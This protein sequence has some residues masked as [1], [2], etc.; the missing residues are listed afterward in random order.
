VNARNAFLSAKGFGTMD[1][2]LTMLP[3]FHARS[4]LNEGTSGT[5]G[6]GLS[7]AIDAAVVHPDRPVIHLSGDS[8]IGFSGIEME[9]LCRYNFP[10]KIAVLNDGG[11]GPG[12]PEIPEH[13]MLNMKP[14]TLIWGAPMT[15]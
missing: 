6:V 11:V 4:C 9:M 8:A 3:S 7:R 14:N 10:L 13:P 2:G 5:M 1:I 12:M 15:V